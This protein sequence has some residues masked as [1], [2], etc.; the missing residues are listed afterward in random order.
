MTIRFCESNR[1]LVI[2][3]EPV[4]LKKVDQASPLPPGFTLVM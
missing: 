1:R 4:P 2:E 3:S